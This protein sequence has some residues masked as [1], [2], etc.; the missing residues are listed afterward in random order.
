MI[1]VVNYFWPRETLIALAT[2]ARFKVDTAIEEKA[3]ENEI[4]QHPTELDQVFAT[5]PFFL[6]MSFS[7][8]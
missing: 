1:S 3:S 7:K 6:V 4:A 5:V 8:P 2:K